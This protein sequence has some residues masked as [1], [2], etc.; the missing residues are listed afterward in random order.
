MSNPGWGGPL[1][2]AGVLYSSSEK[3][4][5]LGLNGDRTPGKLAGKD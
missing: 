1:E 4:K 5:A 3:R 2:P